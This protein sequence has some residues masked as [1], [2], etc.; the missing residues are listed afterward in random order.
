[1][2]NAFK[3]LKVTGQFVKAL[4]KMSINEPTEIQ[5][6]AIPPGL[7]G[8]DVLGVA[9]T[10]SGKT[11]AYLI[12]V[13]MK[14][15]YA[16]DGSPKALIM[17]PSKELAIQIYKVFEALTINTDI[18]GVCL[19][20][21]VGKTDQIRAL[22]KGCEVIIATPGRFLDLYSHGHIPLRKVR[23]L[24]LD[25][26]D[27]LLEMGF[28]QQLRSILEVIPTKRQNL[29]FSATF[30]SVV[31]KMAEEFLDFPT[32]VEGS[33]SEKPV[34][35]LRH[36]WMGVPNFRTK[37][38]LLLHYLEKPD[39][40]RVMVFC[41]TKD[42]ANRVFGFLSRKDVGE[43]RI[44][45]ANKA[46]NTRIHAMEDFE[47]GKVRVLVTTDV[48]SRGIDVQDVS[49]VVNF[50]VPKSSQDYLHRVGRTA[51]ISKEGMAISFADKAEELLLKKIRKEL[52]EEIPETKLPQDV[53]EGEFLPGEQR[54]IA[55]ELDRIKQKQNPDY[56][57]AFHKKKR[58]R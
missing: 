37:L 9:Q 10:G 8:Q 28:I 35:A 47:E 23:T 25:E 2:E 49:H 32:R 44:L 39:W 11:L 27:R 43:V 26:A 3:E 31:E 58:K 57:G 21:G 41:S 33:R 14:I 18:R 5:V 6:K 4:D 16:Q 19:Y 50:N 55:R 54:Q 38:N 48:T 40:K 12:P 24:V 22:D 20:G 7:A 51:R 53:A 36:F 52:S 1:M 42:A 17:V 30:P 46:Q 56:R 34:E 29:L 15:K 13:V 45:H